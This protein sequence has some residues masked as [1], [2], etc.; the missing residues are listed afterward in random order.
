M[1]GVGSASA[2]IPVPDGPWERGAG[3]RLRWGLGGSDGARQTG[4]RGCAAEAGGRRFPAAVVGSVREVRSGKGDD[5]A[6]RDSTSLCAGPC[7]DGR[8]LSVRLLAVTEGLEP[9]VWRQGVRTGQEGLEAKVAEPSPRSW[10]TLG[11]TGTGCL[12]RCRANS[13]DLHQTIEIGLFVPIPWVI[14]DCFLVLMVSPLKLCALLELGLS[15]RPR[16]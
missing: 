15:S 6:E 5:I 9:T 8:T 14:Y 16:G 2:G 12:A 13:P 7:N 10:L 4:G 3:S 1:P 11:L